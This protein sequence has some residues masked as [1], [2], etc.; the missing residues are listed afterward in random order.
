ML[1]GAIGAHYGWRAAFW[2]LGAPGALLALAVSLLPEP[3]LRLNTAYAAPHAIEYASLLKNKVFLACSLTQAAATFCVGGL[4][5]WMPTYFV[6]Y[7]HFDVAKASLV[8]G[9]MTVV[10]GIAGTWLGGWLGDYFLPRSRQSYY[11]VAA[12]SLA[13]ATP[14][15]LAGVFSADTK[16]AL[17][18]IFLAE[19]CVFMHGGP[20]NAAIV[21]ATAPNIRAMAFAANI[22]IIHA[23]GDAVSPA[24]IGIISDARGLRAAVAVC[25]LTLGAGALCAVI[26][27]GADRATARTQRAA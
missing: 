15:A 20:M 25:A 18:F 16:T 17:L 7:F 24:I 3:R 13:L 14:L 22:L 5:A 10:S 2:V 12:A 6:R 21:K 19:T 9:G 26:G 23:F 4:S 1:G 11:I 8:F 27:A